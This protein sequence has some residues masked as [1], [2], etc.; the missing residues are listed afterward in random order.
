MKYK[1]TIEYLPETEED[2]KDIPP[3]VLVFDS[4]HFEQNRDI[5][6]EYDSPDDQAPSRLVPGAV[7]TK[8]TGLT[9]ANG[10]A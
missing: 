5:T 9:A 10:Q 2:A 8:I 3:A 4:L 7:T 6:R 1:C